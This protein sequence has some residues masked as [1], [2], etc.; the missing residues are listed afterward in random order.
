MRYPVVL[1][2]DP[3][4]DY[5]VTVPDLPGC[6]SAGETIDEALA[7]VVEAIEC[8]IEGLLIDGE[9]VP[10]PTSIEMHRDD[11]NYADGVWALVTIDLSKL[12]S[13]TTQVDVTVPER[14]LALVDQ[15]A[16]RQGETRSGVMA[17]A[18]LEYLAA[19]TQAG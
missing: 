17:Q 8:H 15:Y 14:L 5:G 2:K 19:H 11:P 1:H 4:S 7:E 12:S 6:F 3:N 16:A 18:T 13:E 10:S 9:P